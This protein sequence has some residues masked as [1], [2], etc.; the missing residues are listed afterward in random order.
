MISL[1]DEP[2]S[3]A[4]TD[5]DTAAERA[6]T[7]RAEIAKHNHA[8]HVLDSPSISDAEYDGLMRELWAIEEKYP[9]LVTPDSPTQRVGDA[10]VS[11]FGSIVHRRPMLSLGN[12]FSSDELREF[13]KRAKRSVGMGE[14]EVVE[15]ICELKLDGL[16]VS[17]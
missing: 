5:A 16:S 1:F 2:L 8:Y 6:A 13:D 12:A 11:A 3:P 14:N 7:L 15:Y 9:D 10:P 4:K 17:L